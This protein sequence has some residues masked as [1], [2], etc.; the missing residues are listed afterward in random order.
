MTW[1]KQMAYSACGVL[2]MYARRY[3]IAELRNVCCH[4]SMTVTVRVRPWQ[5][6]FL[7][8]CLMGHNSSEQGGRACCTRSRVVW[9]GTLGFFICSWH[10]I[11]LLMLNCST[12]LLQMGNKNEDA[13][14]GRLPLMLPCLDDL[15]IGRLVSV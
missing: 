6:V 2:G 9:C 8:A 14:A 13:A 4:V 10:A 7:P 15:C 12:D 1:Q 5:S 3:V 11:S